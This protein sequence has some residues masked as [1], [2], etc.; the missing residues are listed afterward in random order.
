MINTIQIKQQQFQNGTYKTGSGSEVILILGSCRSVPYLTYLN[1]WNNLNGNRFAIHFIDPFNW[2][3]DMQEQ[4]VDYTAELIKQ[5]SNQ[6]LLDVLKSTN[7]FIHEYY[8]NAEMFNVFK[9]APKNIY[10]FG[11]N[12]SIDI[13]VPNYNDIFVLTREIVSFDMNCRKMA[14]A[15]YNVIGKLSLET[16]SEIEKVRESNLQR[17]YD[18][19]SKTDFPE[20]AEIFATQYKN[21]RFAWTFNHVSKLFTQTIFGLMNSKFLKLDLTNY[22]INQEDLYANNYTYLCEYD[23]DFTWNEEIKPLRDIL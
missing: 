2:N 23:K 1:D 16:I 10:Q 21:H 7:I 22:K 9:D 6:Y 15:D 4:R 12:P 11:L 5:E 17:F 18:I 8:S 13:C 19:C 3:W 20:F 14:I